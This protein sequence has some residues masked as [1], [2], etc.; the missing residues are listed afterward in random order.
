MK[1]YLEPNALAKFILRPNGKHQGEVKT[2]LTQSESISIVNGQQCIVFYGFI[3]YHDT[4]NEIHKTRFCS[5]WHQEGELRRFSPVG[6]PSWTDSP[7][8]TLQQ[9]LDWPLSPLAGQAR[10]TCLRAR[11]RAGCACRWGWGG[12]L[13]TRRNPD[14]GVFFL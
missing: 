7:I 14:L 3:D 5:Y 12:K 4:A 9:D 11:R 6:P 13:E 2:T 8:E 1:Y 10:P